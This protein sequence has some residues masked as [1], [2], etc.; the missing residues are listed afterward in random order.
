MDVHHAL[1]SLRED[2]LEEIEKVD[3]GLDDLRD[4]HRHISW[5]KTVTLED[6]L[7]LEVADLDL[8]VVTRTGIR[9]LLLLVID[10]IENLAGVVAW[11]DS[12][13]ITEAHSTLLNLSE[14]DRSVAIFHFVEDGNS[15]WGLSISLLNWHIIEDLEECWAIIPTANIA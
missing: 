5:A 14:D 3:L 15:E 1:G 7:L 6:L 2:R 8:D 10:D 12:K 4:W 11:S 13:F 9:N